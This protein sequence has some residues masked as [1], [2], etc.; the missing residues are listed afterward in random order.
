MCRATVPYTPI[1]PGNASA[2]AAQTHKTA[3]AAKMVFI[4]CFMPLLPVE[5]ARESDSPPPQVKRF[6][7]KILTIL[8]QKAPPPSILNF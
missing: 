6:F 5:R 7:L 4:A 2:D 8:T 3:A 1:H